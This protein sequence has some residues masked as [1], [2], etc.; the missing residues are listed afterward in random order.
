MQCMH[1]GCQTVI[2][3]VI[4]GPENIRSFHI[5]V[6]FN[7]P[8]VVRS[9]TISFP[10]HASSMT[11]GQ[12]TVKWDTLSGNENEVQMQSIANTC[13]KIVRVTMYNL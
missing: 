4:S 9:Q 8:S 2:Y 13:M 5:H 12:E 1:C 6:S 11:N 7:S 10:K 3:T